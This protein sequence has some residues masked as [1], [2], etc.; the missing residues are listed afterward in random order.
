MASNE[1]P[2]DMKSEQS[3]RRLKG[4]LRTED[5]QYEGNSFFG[6]VQPTP[7]SSEGEV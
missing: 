7:E 4:T 2:I 1:T 6:K 5:T 3:K